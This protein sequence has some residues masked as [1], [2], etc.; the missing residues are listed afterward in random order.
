V[1]PELDFYGLRSLHSLGGEH[2]GCHQ[3]SR[4]MYVLTAKSKRGDERQ[5]LRGGAVRGGLLEQGGDEPGD[6]EHG[7][8]AAQAESS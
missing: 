7:G 2:T 5:P 1:R 6:A 8:G 4:C 3:L